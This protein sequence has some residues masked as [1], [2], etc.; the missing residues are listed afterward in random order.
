[1]PLSDI[2]P[3]RYLPHAQA[4]AEAIPALDHVVAAAHVNLD[5]DALGSLAA[6]AA[7]LRSIGKDVVLMSSTGV[8]EFLSFFPLPAP[9]VRD[10]ADIPYAAKSAFLL[11]CGVF[12]RIG[13]SFREMAEELPRINVD[14]HEGQGIGTLATWVEPSA[15]STTQLMAY[16]ALAMGLPLS[17]PLGD[18]IALG[19][20]TDTGG[21]SHANTSAE[22][23]D[24][25]A[26][27]S[28]SGCNI[29]AIRER[30]D[31]NVR[32]E[33]MRL[34]SRVLSRVRFLKEGRIAFCEVSRDDFEACG[35][36]KDDTEGLVE[37]LLRLKGVS[38][39]AL[40]RENS[41]SDCKFSLRSVPALDVWAVANSLN[42]GGHRNAAGG[43]LK[44]PLEDASRT[45]CNA[46]VEHVSF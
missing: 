2:V 20:I 35:A 12:T 19:L 17:G 28:R 36:N 16:V 26:L 32:H 41:E 38:V 5:G 46:I 3:E 30:L 37:Y 33:R 24:L 7:I 11:D 15:A 14:H 27:L 8:P 40:V 29:S 22:V 25:C 18:A 9:L 23:F 4:V 34:W 10:V 44:F 31:S 21:F 43:T 42:G 13:G 1:M 6:C 45:L 39:S